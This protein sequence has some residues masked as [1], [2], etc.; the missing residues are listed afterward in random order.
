VKISILIL[1]VAC[2]ARVRTFL[3]R[4]RKVR[5]RKPPEKSFNFPGG[6]YYERQYYCAA[7]L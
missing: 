2:I 7:G 4:Q 3:W 1:R 5:K 6:C